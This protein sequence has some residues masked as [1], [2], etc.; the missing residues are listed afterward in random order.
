MR[1][2]TAVTNAQRT[3]I[4]NGI[5]NR[6]RD[7]AYI[8]GEFDFVAEPP[9]AAGRKAGVL[10]TEVTVDASEAEEVSSAGDTGPGGTG[11]APTYAEYQAYLEFRNQLGASFFL[12]G[13]NCLANGD[14]GD[15]ARNKRVTLMAHKLYLD[16]CATYHTMFDTFWLDNVRKVGDIMTGHCNA[17]VTV[18]DTKGLLWNLFEV[19]V[20]ESGVANLLSIPQLE[21]DGFRIKYDTHGDWEV[22]SPDGVL[23]VFDR[24][25]GLCEGMPFT[26]L[27]KHKGGFALIET[28]RKNFEGYTKKQIEKAIL[29]REVQAMTGHYPDKKFKRM[30]S[31]KSVKNCPVSVND[32]TNARAIFGPNLDRLGGATTRQRPVRVEPGYIGIPRSIFE[33]HRLVTLTADVMFVN[34]IPFLVTLS[35]DIRLF[36]CEHVPCRTAAQ[37]SESLVKVLWLYARGGFRVNTIM[38]DMEFEKVRDLLPMTEVNTT[39]AREHVGEIERGIRLLK[40]RVRCYVTMA[41]RAG[42]LY[43]HKL[44][45]IRLVYFVTKCLNQFPAEKG[46]SLAYSPSE[47]VTQKSLTSR[48]IARR[49]FWTWWKRVLTRW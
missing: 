7:K 1:A 25:T 43:L 18:S 11:E 24:D 9:V 14:V 39:A 3:A 30:V 41:A 46:V 10:N 6:T 49:N 48:L 23:I 29:A 28:V 37:L 17:G 21:K 44:I 34:G 19:W 16:S 5:N 40:E 2:C 8:P 26:D 32:V 13:V 47:I 27:R 38:M 33:R 20:N 31:S 45:V 36:T 15:G 22:Y 35:R 4:Y 42:I 12:E